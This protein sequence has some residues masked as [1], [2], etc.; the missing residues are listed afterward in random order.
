MEWYI[1]VL[2]KYAVFT[3]RARR[4]EYWVFILFNFVFGSILGLLTLVPIID[5]LFG[6]ISIGYSLTMIIPTL[7]VSVRR[8]HDIDRS[9]FCLFFA[10]IPMAGIIILLIFLTQNGTYDENK[11]GANPKMIYEDSITKEIKN[12]NR[13]L[14]PILIISGI[15][16]MTLFYYFGFKSIGS[17]EIFSIMNISNGEYFLNV[18]SDK[19]ISQISLKRFEQING[20]KYLYIC[21]SG[22]Y[23]LKGARTIFQ[24]EKDDNVGI[25]SKLKNIFNELKIVDESDNVIWDLND[26]NIEKIMRIDGFSQTVFWNL[27]IE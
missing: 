9:G 17:K 18:V 3:G 1:S 14:I 25:A 21:G 6:I 8:L 20:I 19:S 16:V 15:L 24:C 13:L 5:K 12:R 26:E 4:R 22:K 23:K 7:A 10:F 27:L 11:Y 2:K